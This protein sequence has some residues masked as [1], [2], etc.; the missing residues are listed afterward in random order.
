MRLATVL[1]LLTIFAWAG[2]QLYGGGYLSRGYLIELADHLGPAAPL[3]IVGALV[4][5]VVIGPIPTLPITV[6]SGVLFGSVAGFAWAMAGS[7]LGAAISF[8]LARLAGRPLTER[9]LGGHIALCADCSDRL[10]FW[11][12]AGC[13]LVPVVSFAAVSYGAGLTA[14]RMRAFLVAT[15]IGMIPMTALY[16]AI[17]VAIEFDPLWAGLGGAL[18]VALM[19]ALPGLVERRNPFGMLRLFRHADGEN[20]RD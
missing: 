4:L 16:V 1:L 13:R 20:T 10:L 8:Q 11:V 3:L 2:W 5:A 15:A 17:G 14:M 7:L 18:A 19:L 6:A 9:I 12:V